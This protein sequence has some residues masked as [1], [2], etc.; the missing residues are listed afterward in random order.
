VNL[1]KGTEEL[2]SY[3]YDEIL[4]ELKKEVDQ[5]IQERYG[6]LEPTGH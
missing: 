1:K 2:G 3:S 6:A 4:G 5:I